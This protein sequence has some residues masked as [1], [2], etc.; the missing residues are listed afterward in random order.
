MD[1]IRIKAAHLA[2]EN[3]DERVPVEPEEQ[4]DSI[5]TMI[6]RHK[7]AVDTQIQRA[8]EWVDSFFTDPNY[9]AEAANTLVRIRPEF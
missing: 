9:E 5:P 4:T 1:S 8:S 3:S 7:E 6:D 2:H